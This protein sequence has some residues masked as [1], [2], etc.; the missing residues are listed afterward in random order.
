MKKKIEELTIEGVT[1]VPKDSVSKGA[2]PDKD[3][4]PYKMIRTY[5][6]GVFCGYLKERNGKEGILLEAIRIWK[7]SGAASLSQLSQEGTNDPDNCKFGMPIE[8]LEL[9]EIIEVMSMTEKAQKSIKEK[10][11]WKV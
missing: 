3:G 11:S 8:E 10:E 1:Y 4:L 7:W 6:A 2:E 9:T 5:S